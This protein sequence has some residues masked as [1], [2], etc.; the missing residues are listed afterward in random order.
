MCELKGGCGA[1]DL[2]ASES[3]AEVDATNSEQTL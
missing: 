2:G 1:G 3:D